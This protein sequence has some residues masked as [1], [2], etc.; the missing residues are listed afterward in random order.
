MPRLAALLLVIMSSPSALSSS[1]AASSWEST[2]WQ[3]E[4]AWTAVSGELRAT[5]S[6]RRARL[7]YLGPFDGSH[8]LLHA[9]DLGPDAG[10]EADFGGHRFWLGPQRRWIWP[11]PA[12]WEHAA[13]TRATTEAAGAVL[14]LL[15][16]QTDPAYPALTREYAWEGER[17]R[18]T[19][20]W[21]AGEADPTWF[22][23]HV[24]AV[25]TPFAIE[26]DLAPSPAA[27]HGLV[28]A[29]TVEP[30]EP[31]APPHPAVTLTNGRA[32][33]TAGLS[34]GKFGFTPQPLVLPRPGGWTLTVSPALN[35]GLAG[36]APDAGHLTQV[37]VGQTQPFA[38]LEQLSPYL[39]PAE[40][41]AACASTIWIEAAPAD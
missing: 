5:V 21:S 36:E 6:E 41:T 18:C 28:R 32:T 22:A 4:P 33:L 8:N 27:P 35:Q 16:P 9:P 14:I 13:A 25:A 17:L 40:G 11:P 19:V 15:H 29:E 34:S 1:G 39:S 3:D 20:R 31:F 2:R 26:L 38:E 24:V 37:W 10:P 12:D 30:A 23:L 7:I